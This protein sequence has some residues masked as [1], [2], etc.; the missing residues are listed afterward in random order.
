MDAETIAAMLFGEPILP[1][2]IQ[3]SNVQST[4]MDVILVGEMNEFISLIDSLKM[5]YT[6]SAP[7]IPLLKRDYLILGP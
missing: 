7:R 2:T 6:A 5:I 3:D 4:M 1:L